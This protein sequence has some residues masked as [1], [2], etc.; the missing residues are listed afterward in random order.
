M[1]RGENFG[2]GGVWGDFVRDERGEV[3]LGKRRFSEVWGGGVGENCR[4]VTQGGK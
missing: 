4:S 1:V 2:V 3:R